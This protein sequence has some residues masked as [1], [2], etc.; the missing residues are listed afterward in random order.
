[1]LFS[2]TLLESLEYAARDAGDKGNENSGVLQ[3]QQPGGDRG[4]AHCDEHDVKPSAKL[5]HRF[6]HMQ[7]VITEAGFDLNQHGR[8]DEEL[9]AEVD[10][11]GERF[12]DVVSPESGGEGEHGNQA[13]KDE[14]SDKRTCLYLLKQVEKLV[15]QHPEARGHSEGDNKRKPVAERLEKRVHELTMLDAGGH[16]D[17]QN[18]QRHHDGEDGIAEG[19]EPVLAVHGVTIVLDCAQKRKRGLH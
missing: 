19:F 11:E 4:N 8:T 6:D 17:I 2:A 9:V 13:E 3:R 16:L 5:V 7:I 14:G 18:E 1:V 15:L 10:T 12:A